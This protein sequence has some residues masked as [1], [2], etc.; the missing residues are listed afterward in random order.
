ML[1]KWNSLLFDYYIPQAW[2][3]LLKTLAEDA[4]CKDIYRAWPP[5][6][7][8]ITSGDGLYWQSILQAT[9]KF[10]VKSG[11]AIWPKVSSTD[12]TTYVDLT[13]SLVV[14]RGQIDL[15]V[16]V[17]L[18]QLG[19]TLV[20]LPQTHMEFL[21]DSI[22]KLTPRVARDLLELRGLAFTEFNALSQNQRKILRGY[23]L[24]DRDFSSIYGLPLFPVLNG[25]YVYLE[26][27]KTATRRYIALA[28]DE[29][30]IFGPVAGDAIS[31]DQLQPEVAALVRGEGTTQ[32]NVDLL[33]PSSVIAFLSSELE[34]RSE[35]DLSKFWS[36]LSE[37]RLREQAMNLFKSNDSLRLIPTS[38]G[39]QPVS[40]P[41]FRALDDRLFEKLG[42][43][44]ISPLLSTAVV[45]FLDIHKVVRDID[46]MDEFL[47]AVDLTGLQPLSNDEAKSVLDHISFCY[48]SL[49][50]GSLTKL[51]KLPV[52][53][54]LVPFATTQSLNVC[55]TFVEWRDIDGL[56]VK[57]V[58]PMSLIPLTDEIKFLD[59][60]CSS[61]ITSS[62]LKALKMSV[63]KD[64][65]ILLLALSQFYSQP[66]SLQASFVSYIRGNHRRTN[67]VISVLGE[68]KF[69]RVENGTLQSPVEVIDPNS[70]LKDLFPTE[71]GGILIP[72]MEDDFDRQMLNDLRSL[73]MMKKSLSLDMVQERISY[74]SSNRASADALSIARSLLSLMNEPSFVCFGFSI[75]PS[76]SWLPTRVGLV[77]SKECID[78]GRLDTDLFDE[79]L[80]SL[81]Q[82]ITISPSFR[83]L[84]GWDKPLP[85]SVLTRQL[86]RVLDLPGSDAQ[87]RKVRA[88]IRE[89]A[90]RQLGDADI[91]V[92]EEVVAGRPWVPTE[93]GNLASPSRAV[94]VTVPGSSCFQEIGFSQAEK[95]I[96]SFLLRMGCQD[97]Y[98]FII[99][100]NGFI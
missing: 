67:I 25:S 95:Q 73:G 60:S 52:F 68:T 37:W 48:R 62:L 24:S 16:H 31:L 86:G 57:G 94:F 92:I 17:T 77:S 28:A 71:S 64:K 40:S 54:V 36:W 88:I 97:R 32:A 49:S 81:D 23:F 4:V 44:F 59:Q 87:Y 22:T 56:T 75:D 58:S 33:S 8:S 39:P 72:M 99:R 53:P 18:A 80:A 30:D 42:I 34:P 79:V 51:K 10:A 76:M 47:A 100:R 84:L 20:Q 74:I 9:F 7:S 6:R 96:V 93:S 70:G 38:K 46:N 5:Y 15:D 26:D 55:N 90:G 65:D 45:Q 82:S 83:A 27:R 66:K 3:R 78:G 98:V 19:L 14:A 85:L 29:V 89:V 41:A 91:K 50:Q 63:L 13:S 2:S 61:N 35:E 1:I 11:L 21:N 12:T 69:I 43:A